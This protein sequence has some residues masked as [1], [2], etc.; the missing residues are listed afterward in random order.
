MLSPEA[1]GPTSFNGR[2]IT[3]GQELRMD[4]VG[5]RIVVARSMSV[6]GEQGTTENTN[7]GARRWLT[8]KEEDVDEF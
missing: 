3:P 1:D 7:R 5:G 8:N 4:E 2:K 6:G